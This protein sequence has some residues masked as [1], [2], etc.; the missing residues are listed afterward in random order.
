MTTRDWRI[1][2]EDYDIN[3]R[4]GNAVNPLRSWL[5]AGLPD[6]LMRA[7]Q[8]QGYTDPTPIQRQCVPVGVQSRDLIGLAE[9]GS[10]KTV[11]F[12][13]PMLLHL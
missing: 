3:I 4:G 12:V 2:R 10:G 8:R 5:E 9:T 13:L 6:E 1:V 11:V 7:I